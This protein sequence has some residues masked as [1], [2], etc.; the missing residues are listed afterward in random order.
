MKKIIFIF[1][2]LFLLKINAFA[3]DEQQNKPKIQ[4]VSYTWYYQQNKEI[5]IIGDNLDNC[6]IN[7]INNFPIKYNYSNSIFTFNNK[8]LNI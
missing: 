2:V 5:Q 7:N 8:Q 1:I 4:S 6:K 3:L